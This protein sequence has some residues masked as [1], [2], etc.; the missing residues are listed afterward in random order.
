MSE[1]IGI[2]EGAFFVSKNELIQWVNSTFHLNVSRIEQFGS[3]AVYCQIFDA[4]HPGKITMSKVKWNAQLEWEFIHNFKLLQQAFLKCGLKKYIETEK[5]SKAKY[6]DNLE[7]AQWM[8]RYYDIN[9]GGGRDYD[10]ESRRHGANVD[11]A[12]GEKKAPQVHILN[13]QPQPSTHVRTNAKATDQKKTRQLASSNSNGRKEA[14]RSFSPSNGSKNRPGLTRKRIDSSDDSRQ[15]EH[16]IKALYQNLTTIKNVIES[17]RLSDDAKLEKLSEIVD[18]S[19]KNKMFENERR[20]EKR[21]MKSNIG[22]ID[23]DEREI[24]S[25]C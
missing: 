4:I 21:N 5:L 20:I 11:L 25:Q 14:M 12:F 13:P 16:E 2:M 24:I 17:H 9:H 1:A 23:E 19:M 15:N 22:K 7:F 8:K 10:A 6:Q 18:N 3:G